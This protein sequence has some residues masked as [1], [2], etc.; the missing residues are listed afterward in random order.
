MV[1]STAFQYSVAS[2]SLSLSLSPFPF[3]KKHFHLTNLKCYTRHC[4]INMTI[5]L[6]LYSKAIWANS[7]TPIQEVFL[8]A[9]M[10]IGEV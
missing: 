7:R 8:Q 1:A 4:L 5:Y 2:L 9:N 6:L 10:G 3:F